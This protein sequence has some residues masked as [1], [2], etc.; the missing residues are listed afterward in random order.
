M[1]KIVRKTGLD[2]F[3][4]MAHEFVFPPETPVELFKSQIATNFANSPNN[5]L[6]LNAMDDDVLVGFIIAEQGFDNSVW[7]VQAWSKPSNPKA[8]IDALFNRV[9]LWTI[10]Q[11]RERIQVQTTR[12]ADALYRRFGF[13]E[14]SL[15][16][17]HT[18]ATE[19]FGEVLKAVEMTNGKPVQVSRNEVSVKPQQKPTGAAE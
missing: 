11:G 18:I 9:V 1:I 14:K 15:I 3:D 4:E 7:I 10:S 8:V 13:E 17:E 5:V 12:S 2:T 6:I 16:L 19:T